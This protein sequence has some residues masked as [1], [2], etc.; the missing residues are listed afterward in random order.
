M[1]DKTEEQD[2]KDNAVS[3]DKRWSDYS[4]E[5]NAGYDDKGRDTTH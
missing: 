4:G 1:P 3:I 2:R 5:D